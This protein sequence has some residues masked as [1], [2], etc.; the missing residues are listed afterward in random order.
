M[1]KVHIQASTNYDVLIG[2]GLIDHAGELAAKALGPR[3]AV[4]VSDDT[5][6]ELYGD[7]VQISFTYSGF[8]VSRFTFPAG[9]G[10][11]NLD[12]LGELLEFMA[13]RRVTRS[14]VVVALG[15]G[16]TGDMA[17]FAA[18]VY[19]RGIRFIQ[20]PTTLLAA[21]D[22]SVGGKTAVDLK[23]GKNLA[24]AFHQPSLVVTDTDVIRELPPEQLACGAAEIIKTAVLFDEALFE[25][26]E[27]GGW[28]DRMD[29]VI[30]RCVAI[31]RD[32]VA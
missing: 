26:L 20:I 30:E 3:R 19:A 12:T 16:V 4:I 18:A 14:D 17:G 8:D 21:V 32:V 28:H 5:V 25:R 1:R 29:E 11:K 2:D 15:G 27:D 10:S 22:S 6:D 9:E 7:R 24:G 13:A 31:K 23:G